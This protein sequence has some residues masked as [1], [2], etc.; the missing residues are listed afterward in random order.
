MLEEYKGAHINIKCQCKD[1]H[2]F[3]TTPDILLRGVGCPICSNRRIIRGINDIATT[4]PYLIK[5]FKN[6]CDAYTHASQSN[7]KVYVVCPDCGKEKYISVQTLSTYGI[8]CDCRD[9]NSYPN[10]FIC[11]FLN[12]LNIVY[13]TEVKFEWSQNK[14]YDMY[15]PSL[16]TII[17]NHGLQHY[18]DSFN[19]SSIS[20]KQQQDND[21]LKRKI[22]LEN[23]IKNY[24][25]LDCRKSELEY[26]KKSILGNSLLVELIGEQVIDWRGCGEFASSNLCKTVCQ[27]WNDG[28]SRKE[29]SKN[30]Q[31]C[32]DTVLKYL[33]QGNSN[34]WCVFVARPHKIKICCDDILFESKS[35]CARYLGIG[36]RTLNY[37]IE[38]HLYKDF[39][40]KNHKISLNIKNN[41]GEINV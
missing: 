8:G 39:I 6:V 37:N 34:G 2:I 33:K 30:M 9:G 17:E 15:I 13:K 40:Y 1:K 14:R 16:S 25:S 18:E 5:Y 29:I 10:K 31:L 22:A 4:H 38:K 24:I 27:L 26:I 28:V 23:G 11:G 41:G 19:I 21:E 36:T 7:K 35:E 12:Q 20:L 32:N 3:S